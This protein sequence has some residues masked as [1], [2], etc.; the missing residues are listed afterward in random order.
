MHYYPVGPQLPLTPPSRDRERAVALTYLT[1]FTCYGNRL[2]G[3]KGGSVDRNHNVPG[4]PYVEPDKNRVSVERAAMNQPSYLLDSPRRKLTLEAL[5][6]V[7]SRRSWSLMAAHVRANHVHIVVE[8]N[9]MP[10]TVMRDLKAYASGVWMGPGWIRNRESD[11]RGMEAPVISGNQNKFQP[12]F[13]TFSR[14]RGKPWRCSSR[15]SVMRLDKCDKSPLAHGRGSVRA[16]VVY[17]P[18][19]RKTVPSSHS[20]FR[21]PLLSTYTNRF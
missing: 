6:E 1:T 18:K 12:R 15:R 21:A 2:H 8:A 13:G 9:A 5:V 17:R 11:G 16:D 3:D 14:D 7:C 4:R 20:R 10:E 19:G